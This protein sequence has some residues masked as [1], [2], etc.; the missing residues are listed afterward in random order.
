V[1]VLSDA[2][3]DALLK[4]CRGT[5]FA[6]ARDTAVIRLMIDTGIRRAELIG[7][8]VDEVDRAGRTIT[9]MGKGRRPDDQVRGE[10]GRGDRPLPAP[11]H[12][13]PLRRDHDSSIQQLRD[14]TGVFVAVITTGVRFR[15]R[16]GLSALPS[17]LSSTGRSFGDV[18]RAS[19]RPIPR[20]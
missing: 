5:G 13:A 16:Q 17:C 1:P 2:D 14:R 20:A 6:E 18:A 8:L 11:S 15:P 12:R 7:L 3:V 10:G 9:V 19:R 4:A